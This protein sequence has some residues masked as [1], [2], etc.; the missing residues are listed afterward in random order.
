[1]STDPPGLAT[2]AS[3]ALH[4]DDAQSFV[5]AAAEVRQRAVV[6]GTAIG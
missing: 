2:R 3:P 1:V 4:R 6:R 5:L